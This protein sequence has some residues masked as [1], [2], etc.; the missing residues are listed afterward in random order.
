MKIWRG[1]QL[2]L[3]S[4]RAYDNFDKN[5]VIYH[6]E[7]LNKKKICG[8][9][10]K[11]REETLKQ[12]KLF[13]LFMY[14]CE[15]HNIPVLELPQNISYWSVVKYLLYQSCDIVIAKYMY[16]KMVHDQINNFLF[17][18]QQDKHTKERFFKSLETIVG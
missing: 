1:G 8:F 12:K 10:V 14:F 9:V 16:S 5:T 13:E 3:T 17:N 15:E 4:L 11:R 7:K 18:Q 6:L 2:L